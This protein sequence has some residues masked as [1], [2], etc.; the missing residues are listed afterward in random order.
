MNTKDTTRLI[1][2][3]SARNIKYKITTLPYGLTYVKSRP[4]KLCKVY[5]D[6]FIHDKELLAF[7]GFGA[8]VNKEL[9]LWCYTT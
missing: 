1:Q 3:L 8:V 9:F 5:V 6:R 4:V 7:M 2:Y